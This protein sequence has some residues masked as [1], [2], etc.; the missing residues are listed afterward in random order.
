MLVAAGSGRDV[1][2]PREKGKAGRRDDLPQM[3]RYIATPL[4]TREE[5]Y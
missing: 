4:Y 3:R 5:N 1:Q 2:D